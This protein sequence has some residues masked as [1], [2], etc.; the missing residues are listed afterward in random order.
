MVPTETDD[1][2]AL[3][4]S[5]L[6][7]FFA[8]HY[9][10]SDLAECD[11]TSEY[12][13][14]VWKPLTEQLALSG[15]HIP[16]EYGG[17]GYGFEELGVALEE[18]GRVLLRSPFFASTCLA[19]NLLLNT[20]DEPARR[21]YLPELAA[22]TLTATV[23]AG[24]SSGVWSAEPSDVLFDGAGGS[25]SLTGARALVLDG[26]TADVLIVA[27]RHVDGGRVLAAVERDTPGLVVEPLQTLDFSRPQAAVRF[28]RSHARRLD[29]PNPEDVLTR[30]YY[31]AVACLA[32]ESAGAARACLDM[33]VAY[34]KQRIQFGKAI[35]GFQSIK[36]TCADLL[37]EVELACSAAIAAMQAAD[38]GD[39]LPTASAV[40]KSCV[41]ETF[42]HVAETNI[43]IHGGIGFTWEHDAHLYLRRAASAAALLGDAAQ[44]RCRLADRLSE[45]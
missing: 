12:S 34:A 44:H 2:L 43:Q 22:G 25:G 8:V 7:E 9:R 35:G 16:E 26:A 24:D 33:A 10:T 13:G 36:H 42:L 45:R 1:D 37:V 11:P 40:A 20:A 39:N 30:S 23:T 3:L 41:D 19:A 21:D 6:R 27:A 4:R 5:S 17:Q 32:A 28:H 14:T 29:A 15:L 31:Q 18:S 38:T